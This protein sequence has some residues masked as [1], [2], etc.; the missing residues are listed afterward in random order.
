MITDDEFYILR[1]AIPGP[2]GVRRH[3]LQGMSWTIEIHH[4]QTD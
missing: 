3:H 4:K 2:E 1:W